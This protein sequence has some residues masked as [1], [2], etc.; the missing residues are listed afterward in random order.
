MPRPT[1]PA[2]WIRSAWRPSTA[3]QITEVNHDDHN[4][5]T[6]DKTTERHCS[7]D[8]GGRPVSELGTSDGRGS[9]SV[10]HDHRRIRATRGAGGVLLGLA[11]GEHLQPP[12]GLRSV[13]RA[14]PDEW[15]PP[16]LSAQHAVDAARLRAAGA[17]LGRVPESGRRVRRGYRRPRPQPGRRSGAGLCR[18]VLGVSGRRSPYRRLRAVRGD[19]RN[20]TRFFISWLVRR[21][22]ARFR[23]AS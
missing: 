14:R 6:V 23:R 19:V 15:R 17:T 7:S 22:P 21:G 20:A 9:G 3:A 2:R 5:H 1:A 18:Q 4:R 11:D 10:G 16:V 8:D 12:A 13:S